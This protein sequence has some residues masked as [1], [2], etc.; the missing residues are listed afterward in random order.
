M[1]HWELCVNTAQSRG[2]DSKEPRK[3]GVM[4]KF[5]ETTDTSQFYVDIRFQ[6]KGSMTS[7][8]EIGRPKDKGK[9]LFFLS[10]EHVASLPHELGHTIGLVHEHERL[11]PVKTSKELSGKPFGLYVVLDKL[12]KYKRAS[13]KRQ[14]T[15]YV[16][17]DSYDYRSITHYPASSNEWKSLYWTDSKYN[18][19][20]R[21]LEILNYPS[22]E[23]VEKSDWR[24]SEGDIKTILEL[25]TTEDE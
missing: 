8:G 16:K 11:T 9:A 7:S 6:Y 5:Q 4:I 14:A 15:K 18:I 13:V 22:V 23:E 24:P 3:Q 10:S 1:K 2:K 21:D 17:S 12:N 19:K 25:Y 20:R